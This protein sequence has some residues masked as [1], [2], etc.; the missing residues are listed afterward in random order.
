[1]SERP[2]FGEKREDRLR[3]FGWHADFT[4][5]FYYR[6]KWP[7]EQMSK[8]GHDVRMGTV[9]RA[10]DNHYL[11][12]LQRSTTIE[13]ARKLYAIHERGVPW[14]YDI[15]DA[16]WALTP[17]N[18]GAEH[19][20]KPEVQN[21]IRWIISSAPMVTCS[22]EPLA[23]MI[24]EKYRR[25]AGLNDA[26][27][28]VIP[29]SLPERLTRVLPGEREHV[30]FWRGSPTHKV[31]VEVVRPAL[32]A[33]EKAGA[34]IV[35][36]GADYRQEL[37]L[38]NAEVLGWVSNT[39]DYIDKVRDLKPT[40]QLIPLMPN[41]FNRAKSQV[42]LLEARAVGAVPLVAD[43]EPYR[44][45]VDHGVD[46]FLLPRNEW[47]WK[48]QLEELLASPYEDLR[49]I[50]DAGVKKNIANSTDSIA[51]GLEAVYGVMAAEHSAAAERLPTSM[52]PT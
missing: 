10:A 38:K 51:E 1:M 12:I 50:V 31:D 36:A 33:A 35:L 28:I 39:E 26:T 29:N 44:P 11:H 32:R 19:F 13:A 49:P 47:K 17:D 8:L 25:P 52:L 40:I 21:V 37:G 18:P 30:V 4:G 41:E 48:A 22:T 7:M 43:F 20:W 3:L 45:W 23:E 42:G 34:R 2:R 14:M 27:V 15:D 5:C 46:G 9:S 24:R 6:T 16:I